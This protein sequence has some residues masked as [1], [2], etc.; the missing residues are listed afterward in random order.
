MLS[1][2]TDHRRHHVLRYRP[3]ESCLLVIDMQ[4]YF[5]EEESHAFLPAAPAIVPG[6]VN[7]VKAYQQKKYP[8]IFTRHVNDQHNSCMLARWWNDVL[9]EDDEMSAIIPALSVAGATVI[10]KNQYDAFYQTPLDELLKKFHVTQVVVTGVLTDL[11]CETTARS[12][13][14]RGYEVIA[15]I[16]AMATDNED[17]HLASLST[18]AHGFAI[19]VLVKEL[20]KYLV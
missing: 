9:T 1:R 12:A 5:L 14:V 7:L 10:T 2:F 13:F 19:L 18:L 15:G 4:R 3:R 20:L 16:D 8:V 17:L 6:I 11:C